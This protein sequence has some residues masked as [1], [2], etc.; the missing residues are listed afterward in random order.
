MAIAESTAKFTVQLDDK[1]SGQSVTAAKALEDLRATL[2][3]DK[4]ALSDMNRAFKDM[5]NGSAVNVRAAQELRKNIDLK[6]QAI[7]DASGKM[8]ELGGSL[9]LG[10]KKFSDFSG[11]TKGAKGELGQ[12][13]PAVDS[14]KTKLTESAEAT[15]MGTILMAKMGVGAVSLAAAFVALAAAIAIG[16][17]ALTKF[18]FAQANARRDEAIQLEGLSKIRD[19]YGRAATGAAEMQASIDKV[20]ASTALSRGEVLSYNEQLYRMGLRGNNLKLALEGVTKVASVQGDKEAGLFMSMAAGAAFAGGSVKKL[21]DDVEAR[22]GDTARKKMLSFDVQ[23]KKLGENISLIFSGLNLGKFLE[24]INSIVKL[25]GQGESVGKAWKQIM[26]VLFQPLFDGLGTGAPLVKR[27]IQGITIAVLSMILAVL[28]AKKWLKDT[29]GT[30][31]WLGGLD[32]GTAAVWAG[33]A[34]VVAITGA[35][36]LMAAPVVAITGATLLMGTVLLGTLLLALAPI[37]LLGFALYGLWTVVGYVWDKFKEFLGYLGGPEWSNAAQNIIDGIVNGIK[38]GSGLVWDAMKN[39]GNGAI[40]SFKE[41]LGIHS[42]SRVF[43]EAGLNITRGVEQGVD[44]GAPG[45]NAAVGSMMT[46]PSGVVGGGGTRGGASGATFNITVNA[47]G[48]D[49][50]SIA[51]AVQDAVTRV[52]EGMATSMGAGMEAANV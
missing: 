28:K 30:P 8:V 31:D 14:A 49:A 40:D 16:A 42:P 39:L 20:S 4:K 11:A 19:W 23:M 17:A 35:L 10:K 3:A 51:E 46:V 37:V 18:A 48:G 12:L 32:M 21:A 22:I 44:Q 1:V 38:N 25:F 7:S 27:F 26:E 34:A 45:A 9:S 13:T 43:A 15:K 33:Y 36:I 52:L 47:S 50:T 24:A 6:K 5:N 41:A 2:V 29:F